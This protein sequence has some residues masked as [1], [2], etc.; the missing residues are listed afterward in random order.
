ME[1]SGSFFMFQF[2]STTY[3][4]FLQALYVRY[5]TGHVLHDVLLVSSAAGQLARYASYW[6]M[7]NDAPAAGT[8]YS[9][10]S[11]ASK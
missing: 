11:K 9:I 6:M 2:I 1:H 3:Y 4:L 10:A 8:V 7:E 5:G